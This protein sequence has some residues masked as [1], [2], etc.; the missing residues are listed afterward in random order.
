MVYEDFEADYTEVDTGNDRIQRT[1]THIDFVSS[2]NAE[3]TYVYRNKGIDHFG[4]FVHKVDARLVSGTWCGCVWGLSNAIDQLPDCNPMICVRFYGATNK[5]VLTEISGTRFD[6]ISDFTFT[7]ETWYYLRIE[8]SG[9]S[10]TCRIWTDPTDR[11]NNDT[12]ADSFVEE[13]SLTLQADHK[14]QLI[15]GCSSWALTSVETAT[16]DIENLDLQEGAVTY[17]KTY[18]IDTLIKKLNI[19]KSY[20][21]DAALKKELAKTYT[22]DILLKKPDI[23]KT[24]GL[25]VALLKTIVKS[26]ALDSL[27]KKLD[28]TKTY[29]VDAL[30]EKIDQAVNYMIDSIFKKTV[31]KTYGID[32]Y[33]GEIISTY[34]RNYLVDTLI[35]KLDATK[36]YNINA[37]LKK[38]DLPKTY[39]IDTILLKLGVKTYEID[40]V[41]KKT[42][43]QAYGIDAYF[44]EAAAPP[45]TIEVGA[46][47]RRIVPVFPT[48][49]D[50]ALATVLIARA[51]RRRKRI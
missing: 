46:P 38:L 7:D 9:T 49:E 35:K 3:E 25:D 31:S 48:F 22:T 28:T 23:T 21:L 36:S 8:K 50:L 41:L 1:T 2:R 18:N 12:E 44:G 20:G 37:L 30:L 33:F 39:S 47:E 14:F 6:D 32:A 11:N 51:N 27:L 15:F 42:V 40:A 34:T 45:V 19:T 26:Y 13:L 16:L 29:S 5:I 24:Y 17:T 10:F 4:D 43:S